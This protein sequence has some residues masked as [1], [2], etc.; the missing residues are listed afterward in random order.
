MTHK[1]ENNS[2]SILGVL[3]NTA[4]LLLT[5]INAYLVLKGLGH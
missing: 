3:N 1:K 4:S 2:V 5:C